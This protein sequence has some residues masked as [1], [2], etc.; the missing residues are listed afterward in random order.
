[1]PGLFE[2]RERGYEAKW[3]HDEETHFRVLARRNNLVGH[4][5]AGELGLLEAKADEYAMAVV[6]T[7]LIGKSADPVFEKIQHD[8]AARGLNVPARVIHHK[9]EEFFHVAS[10]EVAR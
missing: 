5:A 8:F 6:H 2:E 1:M 9:M 3:A 4:W 7:G 10:D